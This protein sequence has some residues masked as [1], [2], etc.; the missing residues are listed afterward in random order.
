VLLERAGHR[1]VA[2]S[3]REASRERVAAFLPD[4]EFLEAHEAARR[5]RVVIVA[6]PDDHIAETVRALA[7]A[8]ALRAG[9][10]VIHVSGSTSLE[11]LDAAREVGASILA[12]HPLQSFPDVQTGIDR[13]PGSGMA[14]TATNED[15]GALGDRLAR[16]LGA[17]PFFL[18]DEEKPLYHAAAV[19]AANYLV[20]VEALADRIMEAA[21]VTERLPLL[22]ALAQTSFDR[23]FA[24]GPG[25]ALT[26]PAVRGDSGTIE[27][28]LRALAEHAPEA[29]QPYVALGVAAAGLAAAA[30]RLAPE[31]H[32][33]VEEALRRWT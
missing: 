32:R 18:S 21:G 11:A 26:G 13:L 19:F 20:T 28:N 17:T 29:T 23:T 16:D 15:D 9:Q 14:V 31:E 22:R 6:V 24:V 33:R 7:T 5:A 2:A 25:A 12:L 3:G 27:R 1:V 10:A 8:G 30:G 4:T